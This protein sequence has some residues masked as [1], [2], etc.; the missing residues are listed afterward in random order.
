MAANQRQ[1]ELQYIYSEHLLK[2]VSPLLYEHMI[3]YYWT[4]ISSWKISVQ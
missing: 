4:G 3:D 1:L 2:A